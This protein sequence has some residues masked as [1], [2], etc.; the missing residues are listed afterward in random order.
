ME[1][2]YLKSMDMLKSLGKKPT[3]KEWNKIAKEQNLLSSTSIK[4]IS[5]KKASELFTNAKRKRIKK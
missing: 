4:V 2:I 1:E 5:G 3:Y